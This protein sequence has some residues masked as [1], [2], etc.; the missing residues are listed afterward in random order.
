MVWFCSAWSGCVLVVLPSS[1]NLPSHLNSLPGQ[2]VVSLF[3]A[4]LLSYWGLENL[5]ERLKPLDEGSSRKFSNDQ[6]AALHGSK[7]RYWGAA[8]PGLPVLGVGGHPALTTLCHGGELYLLL[9][10]CCCRLVC[11]HLRYVN[12]KALQFIEI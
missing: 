9:S 6:A 5:K 7:R 11:L 8:L 10:P 1:P 2:R 3:A 12:I 4:L